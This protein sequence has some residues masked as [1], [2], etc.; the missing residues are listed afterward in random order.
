MQALAPWLQQP[1]LLDMTLAT[2]V[3][4]EGY[5]S[6]LNFS[7]RAELLAGPA[8]KQPGGRP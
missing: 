8:E 5:P 6:G 7:I 2:A 1:E 4:Q 3:Q